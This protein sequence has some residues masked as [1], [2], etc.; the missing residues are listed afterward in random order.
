MEAFGSQRDIGTW[1]VEVTEFI[2]EVRC[3]L[4]GRLEAA[5]ASEATKMAVTRSNMHM[6]TRVVEITEL[7]FEVRCDLRGHLEAAM[8]SEATEKAVRGNMHMDTRVLRSLSSIP[9]SDVTSKA[10]WRPPWPQ[11][12]SQ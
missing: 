4:R 6:L 5:I 7:N 10:I 2:S 12:Q 3:D 11:R 1:V 8:A 9:R